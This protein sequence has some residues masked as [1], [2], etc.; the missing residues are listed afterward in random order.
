MP[1][2]ILDGESY[3]DALQRRYAE[4]AEAEKRIRVIEQ[5]K[6]VG[7]RDERALY[8]YEDEFILFSEL[9]RAEAL[10]EAAKVADSYKSIE[11][12]GIA[13][14]IRSLK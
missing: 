12:R 3:P 9:I 7:I 13:E 2:T 4:E 5:A 11:G 8:L 1:T 10:E 14:Q 6:A